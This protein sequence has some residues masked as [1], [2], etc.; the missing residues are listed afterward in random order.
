MYLRV[1]RS[2]ARKLLAHGRS[3]IYIQPAGRSGNHSGNLRPEQEQEEE[4]E[5]EEEEPQ[6]FF[7]CLMV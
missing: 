1:S 5:E 3:E 7:V 6:P 2:I 4:E